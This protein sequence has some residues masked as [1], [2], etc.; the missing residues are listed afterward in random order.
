M[1]AMSLRQDEA[2]QHAP[3]S[4]SAEAIG[5]SV[6]RRSGAGVGSDRL[7][8][9]Q[10]VHELQGVVA[11]RVEQVSGDI[12]GEL[13]RGP[14]GRYRGDTRNIGQVRDRKYRHGLDPTL[15]SFDGE[16]LTLLD[17]GEHLLADLLGSL[18]DLGC[19]SG[20]GAAVGG[21]CCHHELLECGGR[22]TASPAHAQH[23]YQVLGMSSTWYGSRAVTTTPPPS[24][25]APHSGSPPVSTTH[26]AACRPSTADG[27]PNGRTPT[28]E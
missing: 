5:S 13:A 8:G 6:S 23:T 25:R 4:S 19:R 9:G 10:Y 2:A 7:D 14:D 26:P 11:L 21:R 16:L 12:E 1:L 15:G 28:S 22:C 3:G 20:L 17:G 24:T 18:G 27:R